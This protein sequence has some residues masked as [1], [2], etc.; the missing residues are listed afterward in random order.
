MRMEST[1][2]EPALIARPRA[3]QMPLGL[4]AV[5]ILTL[6]LAF[7]LPRN[8][9]IP[10]VTDLSTHRLPALGIEFDYPAN[11]YLQEFD[12][13]VGHSSFQGALISNV[14]HRFVHPDLGP[15]EGTS[16]WEMR[17]LPSDLVVISFE[18][19]DHI[20]FEAKRTR[21]LPVSLDRAIV[22]RDAEEGV[23]TYGAPQP[24]LFLPFAVEGHLNSGIQVYIG[25]IDASERAVI[26]RILAS[27]R[28]L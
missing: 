11:W 16:A 23:D 13:P 19:H 1:I 17:G 10:P 2:R 6:A 9:T 20:N 8:D 3:G 28:P 18:Q 21:G 14:E 27:V 25:D 15:N 22:T 5:A 24:R 7:A 26:E 12:H 4:I